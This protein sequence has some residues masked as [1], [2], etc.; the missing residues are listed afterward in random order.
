MTSASRSSAPES[1][2]VIGGEGFLGAALVSELL[3]HH[4]TSHVAS[5]GLTQ[6]RFSPASYRFFHTDI[7]SLPSL[8]SALQQ[9]GAT[10]VFHAA[11]PHANASAEV[12]QK[13]N[14][15][16]TRVVVEACRQAGVRKLV[17]TSSATVVFEGEALKDVDERIPT[18][19]VEGEKGEPTY[20][21]TK[22]KAEKIVLD[23]NGKD[24]L[25]TC[26]L[27]LSG[28]I[29][30]GD[31]QVIPGFIAVHKSGQSAFQMG[32]NQNLFDFVTVRNVVHAHLLAAERLDAPPVPPSAFEERLPPVACTIKRRRLPTSAH[33]EVI[34]SSNALSSSS[35]EGAPLPASRTRF[36]QFYPPTLPPAGHS[37]AGRSF[38]ISNG[39]PVPFWSFA[40][41]VYCAY[42][43]EPTSWIVRLPSALG[44]AI[45]GA[46]EWAGWVVGKRPEECGINRKH[47]QYV[48][49]DMYFDIERARRL[50]GYEPIESLEEGIRSAVEW[51]KEDEAKQK[52]KQE[53]ASK[54]K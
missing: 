49:S 30:P 39:E 22:A 32:A 28:I 4:P 46:C 21:S 50:L 18:V 8:C 47:M 43:G 11:S 19:D 54:T 26:S 48:L 15:E 2:A 40:R 33:P 7:T 45:A 3:A 27:R 51:Y 6:R 42:S 1:Y 29:G 52:R 17:F 36:N 12:W 9:S 37:V 25:L 16:G 14:V 44:M 5:L 20:V 23:A 38:F 10:T 24:G 53:E 34:N 41:A 31:R 35:S 13:V